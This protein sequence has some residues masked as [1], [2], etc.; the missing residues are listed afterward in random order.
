MFTGKNGPLRALVDLGYLGFSMGGMV[1]AGA[2]LGYW[3]DRRLGTTPWLTLTG[4]LVGTAAGLFYVVVQ[5]QRAS[6]D[7]GDGSGADR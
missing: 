1:A 7:G 2:L 6:R 5:V 3:L 4:T